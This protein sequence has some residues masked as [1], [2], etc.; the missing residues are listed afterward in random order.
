MLRTSAFRF[1]TCLTPRQRAALHECAGACGIPHA[2]TGEDSARQLILGDMR[3]TVQASLLPLPV[4]LCGEQLGHFSDGT[5]PVCTMTLLPA[6]HL[7]YCQH[8][9]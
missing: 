7:Q 4:I 5:N 6:G 1:P 9:L 3:Q 8:S 2:S